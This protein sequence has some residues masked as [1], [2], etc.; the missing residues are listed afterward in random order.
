LRLSS[1]SAPRTLHLSNGSPNPASKQ[2]MA[3]KRADHP[4]ISVVVPTRDRPAPLARCL[5]ALSVQTVRDRLEL[6][7]VDDGSVAADEVAAVVARHTRARLIRMGGGGPAAARNAGAQAARGSF[8]CFT[9]DDCL[10]EVDW[11]EKLTVAI[12]EGAD[13]VAG[14]TLSTRGVLADASEVISGAPVAAEP[15]APSNNFA[16]TKAVFEAVPFDESYR[17]AAA[18]DRDWCARLVAAGHTLRSEPS[19]R[20]LHRPQLT[21]SSFLRRQVRYGQGAYRFRSNA[22]RRL[23]P[24]WFYVALVRR[25]FARSFAVGVLVS[26]AQFATAFGWARGWLELRREHHEASHAHRASA[27]DRAGGGR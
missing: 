25:G 15:F 8:L 7:V 10:P 9:D 4:R 1:S 22:C 2:T 13:A 19:A 6:I 5:D 3:M 27:S 26:L 11:A 20:V 18:E 23:E 24:I 21:L 17:R 14:R 12:R 16:C